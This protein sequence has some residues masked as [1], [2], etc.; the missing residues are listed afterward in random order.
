[1]K[2]IVTVLFL[3]LCLIIIS[4]TNLKRSNIENTFI[5]YEID[6]K[7]Q[8]IRFYWKNNVNENYRNFQNLK[9][10]LQKNNKDLIFAMNGGMYNKDLS[11]QGLYIENCII[12]SRIDTLKNGYGNFY[13]QPNGIFS[14][15]KDNIPAIR[16][17][18]S[19]KNEGNIKYATQSGPMLLINGQIHPKFNLG[20]PNIHIR[21]G[22]GILP[23][24]NLLFA[25]S[26]EKINFYDFASYFKDKGC[27]N[28][29]YLDGFV[30]RTYLP[31]ANW[32]QMEGNF[33]VIIAETK[34][35]K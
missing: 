13:L 21:N 23:N 8:N 34:P 18:T 2:N 1:M 9:S 15:T 3:A 24:G 28:A 25:M 14:I 16:T 30:S 35:K 11:P 32:E 22:V 29:L 33:G 31:S 17:T 19:F 20:S 27:K 4:F 7:H 26:K 10:E 5:S 6:L 12:K